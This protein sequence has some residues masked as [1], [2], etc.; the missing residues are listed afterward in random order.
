V[1]PVSRAEQS[2]AEELGAYTGFTANKTAHGLGV[3]IDKQSDRV[4]PALQLTCSNTVPY[5]AGPICRCS[6]LFCVG[7]RRV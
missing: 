5:G 1:R 2:S 4:L 6:H 7:L 3:K